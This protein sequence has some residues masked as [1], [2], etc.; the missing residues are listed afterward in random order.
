M[1]FSKTR[2]NEIFQSFL[3]KVRERVGEL[4]LNPSRLPGW[5]KAAEVRVGWI[6]DSL[7]AVFEDGA[8]GDAY[9]VRGQIDADTVILLDSENFF[10]L[11]LSLKAR[12]AE[13][14]IVLVG[15]YGED[16]RVIFRMVDPY[17]GLFDCG[18]AGYHGPRALWSVFF[19]V[20]PPSGDGLGPV[21][22]R[23][24]PFALYLHKRD[25]R[26]LPRTWQKIE[27]QLVPLLQSVHDSAAGDYYAQLHGRFATF[28]MTKRTG[29][30]ILGKDSGE[31]LE[32]LVAV[33]DFLASK[34]YDSFLIRQLPEIPAM[35]T[36]EKVGLWT[37][38]TR[39]SVM[40]D[41]TPAGHV[42]EYHMLRGQRTIL[43][44]LRPRGSGST[45][46]IGDDS[47]VDVNFIKL[48]EFEK[49]PLEVISPVIEWA[50]GLV[51]GRAA[52]YDANYPWRKGR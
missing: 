29:V 5:L 42:A 3:R 15:E 20:D 21:A 8:S 32:E 17:G 18:Y 38:A 6:N 1:S 50:E 36:E 13:G 31:E 39:F 33:R 9:E 14:F 41:R 40:V 4:A 7:V 48:F 46:M 30:V 37:Q 34:G 52:A 16:K 26:D 23:F 24:V 2:A 35:S 28:E 22:T 10:P 12:E 11:G 25:T 27:A 49:T 47:L 19:Q 45:Y 44:L 51:R 43:A